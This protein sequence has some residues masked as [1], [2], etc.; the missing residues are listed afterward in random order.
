MV[1]WPKILGGV[2]VL[3]AI[4]WVIVERGRGPLNQRRDRKAAQ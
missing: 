4:S 1:V 2:L 3:A